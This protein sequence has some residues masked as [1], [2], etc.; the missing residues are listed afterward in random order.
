MIDVAYAVQVCDIASRDSQPRYCNKSKTEI[1]EK[2]VSSLISSVVECA[3][4]GSAKHR[5]MLFDDH[6][7]DQTKRLLDRLV[8]LEHKNVQIDVVQ[9]ET[10]GIM[11]S[12]EATYRW[13]QDNGKD[14]V[15]Q[16]QDDYLFEQDAIFE[17]VDVLMQTHMEIGT[18]PL[19]NPFHDHYHWYQSY[20]FRPTPRVVVPGAKRLWIQCYDLACT[21]MTTKHQFSQHWD[22]YHKFFE[23]GPYNSRLEP[24][25]INKMLSERGVLGLMP[26]TNLALHMQSELERDKYYDWEQLWNSV[27]NY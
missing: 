10:R 17:M 3:D 14:V 1:T 25:S 12:I 9:L 13:L 8:R 4:R 5:V 24:D 2:C 11:A 21:F 16:V 6:S 19:I 15:F 26:V 22:L 18:H 23:M 20:R 7:S 27:K